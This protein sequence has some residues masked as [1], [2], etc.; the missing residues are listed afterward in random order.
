MKKKTAFTLV[1]VLVSLVV[2]ATIFVVT[3]SLYQSIN[4]YTFKQNEYANIENI[5]LDIDKVYDK[6]GKDNWYSSYYTQTCETEDVLDE[7]ETILYTQYNVY[8]ASDF[9]VTSDIETAYY[10]LSYHYDSLNNDLIVDITNV[11]GNYKI[12]DSLNY[13]Q[14]TNMGGI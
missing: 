3:L 10:K 1:E 11:N 2:F 6:Y 14:P 12:I 13:G 9:N 4:V 5:C 7:N 8:Y